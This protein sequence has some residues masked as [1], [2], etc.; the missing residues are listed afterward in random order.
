MLSLRRQLQD[1][2]AQSQWVQGDGDQSMM[3]DCK[4]TDRGSGEGLKGGLIHQKEVY[5]G[6]HV[7]HSRIVTIASHCGV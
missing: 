2:C 4:G 5:P 1:P 7:M 3:Q 6:V